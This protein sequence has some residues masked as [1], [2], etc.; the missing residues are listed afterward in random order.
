LATHEICN[1]TVNTAE[2][3]KLTGPTGAYLPTMSKDA[4]GSGC[5]KL[6]DAVGGTGSGT[7][8]QPVSLLPNTLY[9]LRWFAAPG[10]TAGGYL[11]YSITRPNGTPIH[12][13][14][15][16]SINN[17]QYQWGEC[18]TT[19]YS[20]G[21]DLACVNFI[22]HSYDWVAID[23]V[24]LIP[25]ALVNGSVNSAFR[26]V[27]TGHTEYLPDMS[28]SADG[29]GSLKFWD[30]SWGTG[31]S[32]WSQ[33]VGVARNT[34]YALSWFAAPG[35]ATGYYKYRITD[36]NG[37]VIYSSGSLSAKGQK[38]WTAAS[39]AFNSGNNALVQISFVSHSSDWVAFDEV[40]LTPLQ[41]I[42]GDINGNGIVGFEDFAVLQNHYGQAVTPNT[43]GDI[44]GDGQVTFEDFVILQNHYGS[45]Q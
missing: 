19:F 10:G 17:G 28:R 20:G 14:G 8:S 15:P 23:N 22:A 12:S 43:N 40:T 37:N 44:N 39:A 41:R 6:W 25:H 26:W 34:Q 7:W 11:R 27:P 42:P 33:W 9:T 32:K 31:S 24:Q 16:V 35:S 36:R 4:D 18:M 1:G 29:S 5:L 2:A 13:G 21:N 45:I 3:W 30:A 38:Q